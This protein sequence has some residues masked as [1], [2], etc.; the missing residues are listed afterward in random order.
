MSTA[1]S[2]FVPDWASAGTT[3]AHEGARALAAALDRRPLVVDVPITVSA[4]TDRSRDL[5][6]RDEVLRELG[7]AAAAVKAAAPSRIRSILGTCGAE[8]APVGWLNHHYAGDLAVV[9]LDAHGDL[10]TPTS[11]PSKRF[12]GMVLRTLLGEGDCDVAAL[13]GRPLDPAQ[14]VLAGTRDLD[15][16]EQ[17]YIDATEIAV[18]GPDQFSTPDALVAAIRATKRTHVYVHL[19]LDV[20]DP[21]EFPNVLVPAPDGVSLAALGRA[22]EAIDDE[23]DCVGVSVVEYVVGETDLTAVVRELVSGVW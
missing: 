15:P 9:W 3:R 11:S 19:D 4:P 10:N 14:V 2:L 7:A 17:T 1:V 22:L 12:H 16:P 13:V 8:I 18:V 21:K 6:A 23:F 20:L 5:V